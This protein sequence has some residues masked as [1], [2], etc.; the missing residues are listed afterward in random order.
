MIEIFSNNHKLA[1]LNPIEHN[2]KNQSYMIHKMETKTK[3]NRI[4]S[5]I[6]KDLKDNLRNKLKNN[7]D[8][9]DYG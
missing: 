4:L 1:R 3:D 8:N 9:N 6:L 2:I 5:P 7:K